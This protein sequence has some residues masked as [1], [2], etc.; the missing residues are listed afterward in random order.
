MRYFVLLIIS[1]FLL[2]GS[3]LYAQYFGRNKPRYQKLDFKVSE[4]QHFEIYEYLDNP[5]KLKEYRRT[6]YLKKK[7]KEKDKQDKSENIL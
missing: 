4:S 1:L 3:P 6:Y 7:E 2:S 5:E